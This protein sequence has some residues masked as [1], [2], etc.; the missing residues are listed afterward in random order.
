MSDGA[1]PRDSHLRSFAKGISYRLFGTLLTAALALVIT[2][3][4]RAALLIGFTEVTA[5]LVLFW[6][7]ERLWNRVAWGRRH[8]PIVVVTAAPAAPAELKAVTP[9]SNGTRSVPSVA[10]GR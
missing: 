2:G 5:K 9:P 8:T 6:A 1:H 7:H 3:N 4:V 10:R